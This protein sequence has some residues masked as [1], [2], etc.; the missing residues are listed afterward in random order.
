[1]KL[2]AADLYQMG[3][4]EHVIPE[5]EPVSRENINDAAAYSGKRNR[6]FPWK[7]WQDRA[8]EAS[9]TSL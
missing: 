4:I 9:G 2:T 5:A 1:M 3:M 6:R 7:I 8:R